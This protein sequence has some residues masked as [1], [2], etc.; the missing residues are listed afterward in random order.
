MH[1]IYSVMTRVQLFLFLLL[2]SFS[3]CG[4]WSASHPPQS[5]SPLPITEEQKAAITYDTVQP[6]FAQH[7]TDCHG[8]KVA[9]K[10]VRLDSYEEVSKNLEKVDEEVFM[11]GKMP[12]KNRWGVKPLSSDEE[13]ILEAW[14]DAGGPPG[15]P[16]DSQ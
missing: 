3:G 14:I 8:E 4:Y 1:L 13:Q 11:Y 7:C 2:L 16:S 10:K 5:Q 6:I 15:K 12:P 9:K